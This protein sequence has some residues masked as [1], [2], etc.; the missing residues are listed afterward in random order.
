[1]FIHVS[2][3]VS[4]CVYV[5]IYGST[6]IYMYSG[7]CINTFITMYVCNDTCRQ[8][9]TYKQYVFMQWHVAT[10]W[11]RAKWM[12]CPCSTVRKS[13]HR[14]SMVSTSL[15]SACPWSQV[16]R[17][18]QTWLWNHFNG[19]WICRRRWTCGAV[20]HVTLATEP[21]AG[22]H[23]TLSLCERSFWRRYRKPH[24]P[25][26]TRHTYSTQSTTWL[27]NHKL[28]PDCWWRTISTLLAFQS[29][30]TNVQ[31]LARTCRGLGAADCTAIF[32]LVILWYTEKLF[33]H[34]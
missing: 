23:P 10:F 29:P 20:L 17:L 2:V 24:A 4:W 18:L 9:Y 11:G 32:F 13:R 6:Y 26:F 16:W 33:Q 34:I 12:G 21:I 1:M 30:L 5:W 31:C 3:F 27:S 7:V 14:V 15:K 19:G 25:R 22:F 28:L 8:I